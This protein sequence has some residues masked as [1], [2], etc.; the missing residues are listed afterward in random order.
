MDKQFLFLALA[1]VALV[2]CKPNDGGGQEPQPS[3]PDWY[4]TGGELGTTTNTSSMT[5]RQPTPATENA[6]LGTLFAQGDQIAEK[7]FVSTQSGVMPPISP[8]LLTS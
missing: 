1:T 2:A 7:P 8:R 3:L 5:F 6:G 4:Y